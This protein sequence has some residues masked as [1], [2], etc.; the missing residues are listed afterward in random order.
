MW[1]TG[2]CRAFLR[3]PRR[4]AIRLAI[5]ELQSLLAG[6]DR[7]GGA[8]L[9]DQLQQASD[10]GPR[11]QAELVPA[12]QRLGRL[13]LPCR[14]NLCLELRGSDEDERVERPGLGLASEPVNRPRRSVLW[15]LGTQQLL[16]IPL[17]FVRDRE[18]PKRVSED[19]DEPESRS[20]DQRRAIEA[21][22]RTVERRQQPQL[23]GP[24]VP[25]DRQPYELG[26]RPL[27]RR[28]RDE[29]SLLPHE[30]L[31]LGLEEEPELVR[32]PDRAQEPQ[33]IV[34]EDSRRDGA[35]D[36]RLQI[37]LPPVR[38]D[39]I[40]SCQRDCDRVDREVASREV[41]LDAVVQRR[42]VDRSPSL[43]RDPPCA[44]PLGERKG[45]PAGA[46]RVGPSCRLRFAAGDVEVDHLPAEELVAHRPS[47]DPGLLARENLLRELTHRAPP[48]GHAS[49]RSRSGTQARS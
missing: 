21:G 27:A 43:E 26:Q 28:L 33:R 10:L 37:G 7:A 45:R 46:L 42:E 41:V 22:A 6:R 25:L 18:L 48:A 20:V 4:P 49:G 17:R 2:P 14:P 15:P 31:R 11:G 32:E 16:G 40:T 36:L 12:E 38:V 8:L 44:V 47:D 3:L 5:D 1:G 30:A 19:R 39:G 34:G 29:V 9:R 35:D 23:V 13:V 24:P